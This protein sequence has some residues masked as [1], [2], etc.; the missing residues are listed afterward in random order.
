MCYPTPGSGTPIFR[1]PLSATPVKLETPVKLL[2]WRTELLPNPPAPEIDNFEQN[3]SVAVG[4]KA[5]AMFVANTNA[6]VAV[7]FE[8]L[9]LATGPSDGCTAVG[10][11]ALAICQGL[12]DTTAVGAGAMAAT[13]I[14]DRNTCVGA[15]AGKWAGCADPALYNHNFFQAD[16][17]PGVN[18]F[19]DWTEI[20]PTA[21][22]IVG[23][24]GTPTPP[25]PNTLGAYKEDTLPEVASDCRYNV[26]IG[27]DA[28]N[29]NIK[30]S[31]NTFIG[32]HCGHGWNVDRSTF[33]GSESGLR[34]LVAS[35]CVGIGYQCLM[36][37]TR[38]QFNTAGGVKAMTANA[39]GPYNTAWGANALAALTGYTAT[40]GSDDPA[41]AA[42][43]AANNTAIGADALVNLV[44]GVNNTAVGRSA[45]KFFSGGETAFD[46]GNNTSCL[47][48]LSKVSGDNQ[49]QLG[50]AATTTYAYGA[51]Q[52]RSDEQDMT[53]V[54]D[55]N[56]GLEFIT[57]LRA[58]DFRRH[59][60]D[61]YVEEDGTVAPRDGSR[62]G[63]RFH[64]GF[65][66]QEMK[67]A[68]DKLGI[69]FGG[70]QDHKVNGGGDVLTLGYAELI[71]PLVK[72][73]QE[74][75]GRV[76]RIERERAPAG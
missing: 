37:N 10:Y 60:R 69:D 24:V 56:L 30:G 5:G 58:V 35:D 68:M 11:K 26:Y 39:F 64:H 63:T 31:D 25:P 76:A 34:A 44:S 36:S 14:S 7:G 57:A 55:T 42:A 47:G 43:Q 67:A 3:I 12:V 73:V 45:G 59:Y 41:G 54:R 61:A 1:L 66:A 51:V 38:G 46:T 23:P 13:M 28:G 19:N 16:T 65:V 72:A 21:R 53:D 4:P 48:Y 22:D 20:D 9:G 29:H 75:S 33:I 32:S 74:L 27:R 49:V 15:A 70:Y 8:A 18:S 2:T 52:D 17:A 71:A 40:V 50:N 6:M 62:A